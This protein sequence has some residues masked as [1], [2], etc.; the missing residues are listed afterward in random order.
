M[1]LKKQCANRHERDGHAG[2]EIMSSQ[3]SI[4]PHG[5][6]GI[7]AD[8]LVLELR[9]DKVVILQKSEGG[10]IHY[11]LH[12]G[13]T[14]DV[15]DLHRT[16]PKASGGREYQRLFAIRHDSLPAVI[17]ELAHIPAELLACCGLFG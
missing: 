6:R 15:I 10:G 2:N 8:D 1:N 12:S 14:S 11:T 16:V 17:S 4:L 9:S 13:R 5:V 7:E 3:P